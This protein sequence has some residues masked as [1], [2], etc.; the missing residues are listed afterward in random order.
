MLQGAECYALTVGNLS[1][2]VE[3]IRRLLR[4]G[5]E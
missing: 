2:A 4:Q 3:S 5:L 1:S